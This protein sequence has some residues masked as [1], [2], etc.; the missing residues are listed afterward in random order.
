[1]EEELDLR[2]YVRVVFKRWKIIGS[3]CVL[4]VIAA[5]LISLLSPRA[6]EASAAVLITKT[7][8]EIILEP[9]Y[10]T[11]L[12]Q[13]AT[14]TREALLALARSDSLGRDIVAELSDQAD[15]EGLT[16][17][18]VLEL[19]NVKLRGD[20]IEALVRSGDPQV[21]AAVANAW[22]GSYTSY[23]NS[24]Y[25]PYPLT[26]EELQAQ[27]D[28]AWTEYRETQAALVDRLAA[29]QVDQLERQI[30]DLELLWNVRSLRDQ[31]AAG[32]TSPASVAA[33]TLSLILLRAGAFA[34]L[35][36]NSQISLSD[37]S[38]LAVS[39]EELLSTADTL[40]SVLEM[41]SGTAPDTSPDDLL[42]ELGW[43]KSDLEA[44]TAMDNEAL[45]DRDITWQ[46][47][48]TLLNKTAEVRLATEAPDVLVTLAWEATTPEKEGL[49]LSLTN[50]A[51]GLVLG[52]VLGILVAFGVEY[53]RQAPVEPETGGQNVDGAAEQEP[54]KTTKG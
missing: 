51:I 24:L 31:I 11:I 47:Y 32:S 3:I 18:D 34:D 33:D 54:R 41:R 39:T 13:D 5:V 52:L 27:T 15:L 16:S 42:L 7:R 35:P 40:I 9:K 23:V 46:T 50:V 1:M 8:S 10:K 14:S 28:A 36:E 37:L 20:L 12:E 49:K 6:Y 38:S 30:A 21:A 44:E 4:A 48:D 53:F 45:K 22:A 19:I 26:V 43:L 17:D 25:V 2:K 29:S